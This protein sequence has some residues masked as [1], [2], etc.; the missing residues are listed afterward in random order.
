M[1]FNDTFKS[2]VPLFPIRKV[3][4]V[5]DTVLTMAET[6]KASVCTTGTASTYGTAEKGSGN[7]YVV[8]VK[9][10]LAVA[11][12]LALNTIDFLDPNTSVLFALV[13]KLPFNVSI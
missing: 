5:V 2:A 11:V 6:S 1:Q 3:T 10:L 7:V 4:D 13:L 8:S 12:A 9:P